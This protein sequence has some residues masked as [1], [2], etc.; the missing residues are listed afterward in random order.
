MILTGVVARYFDAWNDHDAEACARCFAPDGVREWRVLAPPHIGGAPFPRFAGR[1]PI[2][3]R[4]AQF[5]ASVPDLTLAVSALSEGSDG[6]VWTEW[7][8]R[9]THTLDL[10]PWP[11][12]GEPVDFQGVSIFR[13]GERGIAEE[14]AYWDTLLMLGSRS[15]AAALA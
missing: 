10:G 3:D 2:A 7:R 6:R 8:L 11:A 5:I 1:G 9:G 13:I 15:A 14:I 12:Q 4:I